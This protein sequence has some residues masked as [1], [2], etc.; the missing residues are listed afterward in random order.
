VARYFFPR[1]SGNHPFWVLDSC[2]L[3]P[4]YTVRAKAIH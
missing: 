4:V 1:Q 3:L 2:I